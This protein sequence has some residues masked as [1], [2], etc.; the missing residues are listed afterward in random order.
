MTKK[1]VLEKEAYPPGSQ[2]IVKPFVKK[3]QKSINKKSSKSEGAK[4]PKDNSSRTAASELDDIFAKAKPSVTVPS[5]EEVIFQLS[6]LVLKV[7]KPLNGLELRF[8][9]VTKS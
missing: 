9:L 6:G 2:N 5:A 4:V 8:P 3:T 7:R 1:K